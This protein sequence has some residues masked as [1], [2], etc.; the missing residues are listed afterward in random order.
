M[1]SRD[2]RFVSRWRVYG[3]PGEIFAVLADPTDLPRWWPSV[4]LAAEPIEPGGPDGVGRRVALLTRGWLPYTLAWILRV[5]DSRPPSSLTV[6]A[7]GDLTGQGTWTLEGDGAWVDVTFE[8]EVRADKPLLAILS[9]F[10]RPA[11]A[12]NHRWSMARGEESLV[13]EL[14]HRRAAPADRA[15]LPPPPAEAR[16]SGL[17]LAAGAAGALGFGLLVARLLRARPQARRSRFGRRTG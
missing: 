17:V 14:A 13:R 8:W 10:L 7:E 6:A 15:Q 5:A 11:L 3:T 16:H 4:Y 1:S 2:Y 9:P 12:A